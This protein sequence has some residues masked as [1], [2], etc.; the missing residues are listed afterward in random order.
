M[1]YVKFRYQTSVTAPY[2]I[3][4]LELSG[5]KAPIYNNDLG[6][7]FHTVMGDRPEYSLTGRY[8]PTTEFQWRSTNITETDR[9]AI[10]LFWETYLDEGYNDFSIIDH[11]KRILFDASWNQWVEN[12]SVR[13]GGSH[14]VEYGIDSAFG[15]TPEMFDCIFANNDGPVFFISGSG[16]VVSTITAQGGDSDVLAKNGWAMKLVG[17]D[18][19]AQQTCGTKTGLSYD[20]SRPYNNISI[21]CQF[22][23]GTV[24]SR[25]NLVELGAVPTA[26]YTAG[27][28]LGQAGSAPEIVDNTTDIAGEDRPGDD[29]YYSIGCH[30]QQY[31]G[32]VTSDYL[33]ITV[34]DDGAGGLELLGIVVNQ[35]DEVVVQ[36]SVGNYPTIEA[37]Q[38]YDAAITYDAVNSI[39]KVFWAEASA[40]SFTRFL[41]GQT[42]I[43]AGIARYLGSAIY[44]ARTTYN[45]LTVLAE[46]AVDSLDNGQK[47]LL[48]NVMLIDGCISEMQFDQLRK[49]CY[50]WNSKTTGVW[51]K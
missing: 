32:T 33:R 41:D 36:T 12:W 14:N 28:T 38:W 34:D 35:N 13:Y 3:R 4:S 43:T 49:L 42:S 9:D 47:A 26:T 31:D 39:V 40:D 15:W 10:R 23:C 8:Y 45:Q 20:S 30:E 2:T 17:D 25:F 11:R 21:F 27:S 7:Q 1:S 51:P 18:G 29:G 50:M 24:S 5:L 6:V 44:P 37:G 22:Y 16:I 48:Q 19:S 46:T